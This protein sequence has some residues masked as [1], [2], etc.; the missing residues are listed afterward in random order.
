MQE[1][2]IIIII[3]VMCLQH[4]SI[5]IP[6]LIFH[7]LQLLP[8]IKLYTSFKSLKSKVCRVMEGLCVVSCC[9]FMWNISAEN[10]SLTK[11]KNDFKQ[12]TESDWDE[13]LHVTKVFLLEKK[14]MNVVTG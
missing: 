8:L 5:F 4:L 9:P 3:K 10:V 13:F 7:V 1:Q 12:Q 6:I 2:G 14:Q 11:N